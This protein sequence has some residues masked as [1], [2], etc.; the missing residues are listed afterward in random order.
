RLGIPNGDTAE[1]YLPQKMGIKVNE[2]LNH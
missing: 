2:K 1:F